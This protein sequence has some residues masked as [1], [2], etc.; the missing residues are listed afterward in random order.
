M[1]EELSH[2][3]KNLIV[4]NKE[5]TY[6]GFFNVDELFATINKA[7]EEKGYVK[8]EKRSEE[9]VTPVGRMLFLELRPYKALTNYATLTIK[10]KVTLDNVTEITRKSDGRKVLFQQGNIKVMFDSWILTDYEN[11]WGISPVVYFLKG[12]INKF[13]Y[14]FPL[15]GKFASE[16]VNDTNYIYS[17][18]KKLLKSYGEKKEKLPGEEEVKRKIAVEVGEEIGKI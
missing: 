4:N 9:L 12:I 11:R 18:I 13:V 8:N 2:L 5:L 16:L 6:K 7:I 1:V 3:E 17:Q 14:K 15:E 10:I